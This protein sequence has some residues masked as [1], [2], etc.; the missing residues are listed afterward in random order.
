M[1]ANNYVWAKVDSAKG[2]GWV[3]TDYLSIQGDGSRFGLSKGDEFPAP[4]QN[5]WWSRGQHD[6]RPDGSVDD[7]L[8]W[9][10]GLA[11]GDSIRSAPAVG[12]VMRLLTCR[13]CTADKPNG[14]SQGIPLN[15]SRIFTEAWG[16]GYGNAVIVRYMNDQLPA[17]ARERLTAQRLA[18]MHLYVLYGHLSAISVSVGQD[19]N[20]ATQVGLAG[21]TGN[22]D[23]PHLHLEV[24]ASSNPNTTDWASMRSNVI[25]P[26]VTFLR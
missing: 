10:F 6:V 8:G 21:N 11:V 19:L 24:R 16:F 15:D 12:K 4:P 5:Y 3:R 14:P 2:A 23:A 9:D 1:G 18:G 22:S 13:T 20:T 25:D 7:H 26:K 17:S